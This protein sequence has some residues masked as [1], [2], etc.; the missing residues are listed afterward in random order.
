MVNKFR[1]NPKIYLW[2]ISRRVVMVLFYWKPVIN[3]YSYAHYAYLQ[4]IVAMLTIPSF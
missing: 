1:V 2:K 3:C 4:G